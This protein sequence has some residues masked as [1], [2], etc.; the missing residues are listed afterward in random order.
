MSDIGRMVSRLSAVR[1]QMLVMQ[2]TTESAT[3]S[4]MQVR[5]GRVTDSRFPRYEVISKDEEVFMKFRADKTE[6]ADTVHSEITEVFDFNL[7]RGAIDDEFKV[8]LNDLLPLTFYQVNN[9]VFSKTRDEEMSLSCFSLDE[10]EIAQVLT[11]RARQAVTHPGAQGHASS[12]AKNLTD[13]LETLDRDFD[14]LPPADLVSY[15]GRVEKN[16]R[17]ID[18][19]VNFPK[20]DLQLPFENFAW[21]NVK[22][23]SKYRE[24]VP[25][26]KG[27]RLVGLKFDPE[28]EGAIHENQMTDTRRFFQTA[29]KREELLGKYMPPK[30]AV[31]SENKDRK[32]GEGI[33][34]GDEYYS[35]IRV[36]LADAREKCTNVKLHDKKSVLGALERMDKLFL[37]MFVN[38]SYQNSLILEHNSE[39]ETRNERLEAAGKKVSNHLEHLGVQAIRTKE[40]LF[41]KKIERD[42]LLVQG[43]EE[44]RKDELLL[45]V[46]R[47]KD[48]LEEAKSREELYRESLVGLV[49]RRERRK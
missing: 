8:T 44:A 27:E 41:Q 7:D 43:A 39:I 40:Q 33:E 11:A 12:M 34:I 18:S 13:E 3:E 29:A 37:D 25:F 16:Y 14:A 5:Y 30:F 36:N 45:K 10:I 31:V 42:K 22:K 26:D 21:R 4:P 49:Y 38:M 46:H 35:K 9:G 1:G 28:I 32:Q 23:P 17:E 19:R 48:N 24:H 2:G 15:I 47:E 6:K 20:K